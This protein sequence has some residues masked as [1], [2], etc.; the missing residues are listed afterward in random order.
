MLKVKIPKELDSK[1]TAAV[2]ESRKLLMNLG[3]YV[4]DVL[5]VDE[6]TIDIFALRESLLESEKI[7]IRI[8]KSSGGG[9]TTQTVRIFFAEQARVFDVKGIL[10]SLD[11]IPKQTQKF[12]SERELPVF[13]S[14]WLEKWTDYASSGKKQE[15][16]DDMS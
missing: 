2:D 1:L 8:V 14:N 6:Y 16:D 3:Y 13:G 11:S 5:A 4:R 12:I 10:I 9:L 15:I 7:R